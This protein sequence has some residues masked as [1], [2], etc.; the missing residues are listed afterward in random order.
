MAR[1]RLFSSVLIAAGALALTACATGPRTPLLEKKFERA[2]STYQKYDV[3]GQTI[4]CKKGEP[5][6]STRLPGWRCVT[7]AQLRADVENFERTRHRMETP[8]HA[9]VSSIG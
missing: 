3:K 2:A 7:E 8:M 6:T 5:S 4:Y 9:T 1:S